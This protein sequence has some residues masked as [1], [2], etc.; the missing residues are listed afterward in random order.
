MKYSDDCKVYRIRYY[1]VSIKKEGECE[2]NAYQ[3][4]VNIKQ[5][6]VRKIFPNKTI[7]GIIKDNAM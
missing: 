5:L 7:C 6:R 1:N 4:L 2:V 3:F